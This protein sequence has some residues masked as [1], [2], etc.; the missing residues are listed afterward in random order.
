MSLDFITNSGRDA[1]TGQITTDL[2]PQSRCNYFPYTSTPVPLIGLGVPPGSDAV[3]AVL[4]QSL[5]R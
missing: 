3:L 2:H 4:F 1:V 5:L